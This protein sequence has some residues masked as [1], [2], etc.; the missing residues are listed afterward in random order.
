M[1]DEKVARFWDNYIDKTCSY[2]VKHEV[3]RWYVKRCEEYIKAHAPL[4]LA[5]HTPE[6]IHRYLE[7][8]GRNTRLEDWQL[9]QIVD[10]LR[11][12]FVDLVKSDWAHTFSWDAYKD[13]F[14]ALPDSHA[15]VARSNDQFFQSARDP[16][17]TT[18]QVKKKSK[19]DGLLAKTRK[20]FPDHIK[21]MTALIRVKQYSIRTE[22]SYLTWL[23]RFIA[24]NDMK[25][26]ATLDKQA[27][28]KYLEYLALKRDVAASTQNQALNALVFYYTHVLDVDVK[29]FGNFTH[30]KRPKRL[31]VVLTKEETFVLLSN[32]ENKTQK[33]MAN[34]LYGCGMRLMECI[35]LRVQDVDFGYHHIVIRNAKGN[36]D[37]VVPLP[38]ILALDLKEQIEKVKFLHVNDCNDGFGEVY[39]PTALT[40]KYPNAAKEFSW[41]YVFPSSKISQDP[42]SKRYRRHHVHENGLQK[43]IKKAA[44][45]AKIHKKVNCHSLRHSFA[46]HL[47]ESG[48]DI[49]T[50]QELLGHA[51]VSTTMIYTHVLNKPGVT[52]QSP[53]DSLMSR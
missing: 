23:C 14:V 39:L 44:M 52:V 29:S 4:R 43:L 41:Q 26:P 42:R 48:Q 45:Q 3:C 18:P 8:L 10:A 36:K 25:D 28:A 32:I 34:L 53:L 33:L 12:L 2:G 46:T 40:R 9:M 17:S 30:A 5:E 19:K 51:D 27:I 22:Q 13:S 21:N 37:R 20:L 24:F 16:E 6:V 7:K 15:T 31:P 47:L 35:R 11:V 1:N 50:V 38:Q 49:R